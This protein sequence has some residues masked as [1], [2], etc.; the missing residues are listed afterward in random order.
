MINVAD[1]LEN[2]SERERKRTQPTDKEKE[3]KPISFIQPTHVYVYE[4]QGR[5]YAIV[6]IDKNNNKS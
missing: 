1:D 2:A 3:R 6:T 5:S 4:N